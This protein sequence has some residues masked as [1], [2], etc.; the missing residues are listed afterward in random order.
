MCRGEGDRESVD[1]VE[2]IQLV[3]R[4]VI[5]LCDAIHALHVN[6]MEIVQTRAGQQVCRNGMG[7]TI[8]D[9]MSSIMRV[10]KLFVFWIRRLA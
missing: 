1:G 8:I 2:M 3:L 6:E 5:H 4:N 7:G 10:G 9:A